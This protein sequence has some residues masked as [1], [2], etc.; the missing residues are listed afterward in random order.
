ME[1]PA[2][3]QALDPGSPELLLGATLDGVY[4][5]DQVIARGATSVVYRGTNIRLETPVAIKVLSSFLSGDPSLM[6][7]FKSEAKVQAKLRHPSI[8][9]VQDY[10]LDGNICA[11]V[12]EYVEGTSLEHLM[13][14]LAGPMPVE[15]IKSVMTPVLDAISYAHDQGIVHRDIKPSNVLLAR[16]GGRDFPK[17]MDFGIAKVLAEGGSQTAPGAML[18]TLLYMSPEQCKALKTVDERSDI[19]SL[20]VTLYQM[21]TGM[22]PFY[23]ESAF[24]IMLAHVQTPPPPPRELCAS[25]PPELEAVILRALSKDPHERFQSAPEMSLAMDAVPLEGAA[26]EPAAVP[27]VPDAPRI[28]TVITSPGGPEPS[29]EVLG[30][31]TMMSPA[32]GG[33]SSA[34]E[35]YSGVYHERARPGRPYRSAEVILVGRGAGRKSGASPSEEVELPKGHGKPRTGEVQATRAGSSAEVLAAEQ[36]AGLEGAPGGSREFRSGEVDI[37]M[38]GASWDELGTAVKRLRLRVPSPDDWERY[39]DPNTV[40][41]GVFVPTGEPPEVGTPVRVE[42]TF[43]GGPRFFVRGVVT[44]RRPKLK[45]PRARAGAGVQVHP[46]ERSKMGYVNAWVRG[47]VKEQRK[48]RRLPLKL[49]VTYTARTGRRINFTRDVNEQGVFVRS[50]ELLELN[51]PIKLLLMPPGQHKPVELRGRVTRLVEDREDRGMGI[52]LEFA[53]E[54]SE[55]H[56]TAFI[57]KLEEEFLAGVLPDEVVS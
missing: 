36:L 11:I 20:G 42:I 35:P 6:T 21:A 2:S 22:V 53:D 33:A 52:R 4:R 31:A 8:V 26:E 17:V 1:A 56:Y 41:G 50:H 54:A 34:E 9:A 38:A 40:G 48:L 45:D 19:Y 51:T 5:V 24:D 10:V 12:M 49:R 29:A 47:G 30:A 14:D 43:I 23:S 15:Q 3:P 18:G 25:V 39:F 13:Y 16:V 28:Q 32:E 37:R 27:T 7:R 44:W 46:S 57:E 55:Q